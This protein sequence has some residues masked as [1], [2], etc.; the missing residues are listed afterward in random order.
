MKPKLALRVALAMLAISLL[1]FSTS[2]NLSFNLSDPPSSLNITNSLTVYDFSTDVQIQISFSG[3]GDKHL[4]QYDIAKSDGTS[5]IIVEEGEV[6]LLTGRTYNQT[7]ISSYSYDNGHYRFSFAVLLERNGSYDSPPFLQDSVDFWIDPTGPANDA[8]TIDPIGGY[9]NSAQQVVLDH[10]E[11]NATDGSPARIFYTTDGSDPT[12][13][14]TS[15]EY[16]PG[17]PVTI[18][19]DSTLQAIA[20]DLADRTSGITAA[21]YIIDSVPPI[22]PTQPTSAAGPLINKDEETAGFVVEVGLGESGAQTGDAL[23]LLLDSSSFPTPLIHVLTDADISA[24]LCT[25]NIGPGQLGSD[26]NKYLTARVTDKA[27]NP[28]SASNALKLTLDATDPEPPSTSPIPGTYS[29]DEVDLSHPEWPTSFDGTPVSLYYTVDGSTPGASSA[30]YIGTT[31]VLPE[32]STDLKSVAI[33][34]AGNASSVMIASFMIDTIAPDPPSLDHSTGEYD[35]EFELNISHSDNPP[36]TPVKV[37]YTLDGTTPNS[38][39]ADTNPVPIS[40]N[41]EIKAIAIDQVGN[42]STVVSETYTFLR[43]DTISPTYCPVD[44]LDHFFNVYGYFGIFFDAAGYYIPGIAVINLTQNVIQVECVIV[45]VASTKTKL[46]I[47]IDGN[48]LIDASMVP[49]N[50]TIT[51]VSTVNPDSDSVSFTLGQ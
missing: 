22:A 20:M 6:E 24:E 10:P 36:G 44:D 3:E 16:V 50:A 45:D 1:V 25:F 2:C 32:G 42:E 14:P 39:S 34:E 5:F 23:E 35:S 13:S 29:S 7:D 19:T 30:E 43:V 15:M 4:C 9:Y 41:T 40:G 33:D 12:S 51:V 11:L 49:G 18:A 26:G 8:L 38:S 48:D 27:G 17:E 28:G 21:D 47:G 37:Y 31:I 46:V